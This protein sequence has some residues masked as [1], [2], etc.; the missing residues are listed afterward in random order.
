MR[1]LTAS[2]VASLLFG[3]SDAAEQT[4]HDQGAGGGTGGDATSGS[5]SGGH[6]GSGGSTG[7][8]GID[9]L[10]FP[11]DDDFDEDARSDDLLDPTITAPLRLAEDD[12]SLVAMTSDDRIVY[13]TDAL[14]S[15]K[16]AG[17]AAPRKAASNAG[18]TFVIG[19]TIFNFADIDYNT[20]TGYLTFWTP[21]FGRRTIGSAM[22][23]SDRIAAR[24]DDAHVM[25]VRNPQPSTVD[26]VI[27]SAD[28]QHAEVL[29][30]GAGRGAEDT[31]GPSFGF[32]GDAAVVS[33]C[34][35]GSLDATLARFS[36]EGG[37][38]QR[39][40]LST[41]ARGSWSSDALGQTLFYITTSGEG[42]VTDLVDDQPVGDNVGWGMLHDDGS[43]VFF[44]VSDQL[45]KRPLGDAAI[46]I[47]VDGFGQ[48]IAWTAGYAE[49][50]YTDEVVYDEG[51]AKQDLSVTPTSWFN[52]TPTVLVAT[53]SV[54]LGRSVITAAGGHALYL[55]GA[56][57]QTATL[58][59]RPLSGAA[60]LTV[61]GVVDFVAAHDSVILFTNNPSPPNTYPVLV[62]L[63]RYDAATA[64]PP[65]LLETGIIDG[66]VQLRSDLRTVIYRRDGESLGIWARPIP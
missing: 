31:C 57:E 7:S 34:D 63:R 36:L 4:T 64:G 37:S 27:C 54:T 25:F 3:C 51:A 40:D 13:R 65:Q 22:L 35:V 11:S 53:P 52:P 8:G 29:V 12:G 17:G 32:A 58:N 30:A 43:E 41:E 24:H 23:G 61:A 38:W 20:G 39:Q 45:R 10:D 2:L 44:T 18:D 47:V 26:I 66:P 46:P 62:D 59:L 9:S 55:T 21:A 60:A 14:W 49:V 33:W 28:K 48:P 42:R 16:V 6:T 15:L 56:D 19:R 50:L 5:A 1:R